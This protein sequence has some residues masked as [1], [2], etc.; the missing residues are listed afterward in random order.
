MFPSTPRK[1]KLIKSFSSPCPPFTPTNHNCSSNQPQAYDRFIPNS[2]EKD[3]FNLHL[4]D[5]FRIR[6]SESDI[7]D[8]QNNS[9]LNKILIE[10]Q[11]NIQYKNLLK[12]NLVTP[13]SKCYTP[14]TD[15]NKFDH[16]NEKSPIQF[17]S[18]NSRK[19][20]YRKLFSFSKQKETCLDD[21][22]IEEGTK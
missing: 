20:I 1:P 17:D 9:S 16:E 3:L 10:K 18:S 14:N 2:I 6:R 22:S 7:L 21:I 19:K 13:K 15:L 8:Q 12:S 11:N 5:S 4:S